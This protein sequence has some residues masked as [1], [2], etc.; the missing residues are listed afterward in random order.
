MRHSREFVSMGSPYIDLYL[1]SPYIDLYL[2]TCQSV[3]NDNWSVFV[4]ETSHLKIYVCEGISQSMHVTP[5]CR[6]MTVRIAL[7]LMNGLV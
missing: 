5:I 6:A 1:G 2:R 7:M 4:T 3:E